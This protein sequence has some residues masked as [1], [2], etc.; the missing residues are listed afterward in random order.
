MS[1]QR[2]PRLTAGLAAVV[3]AAVGLTGLE[4]Q[5]RKP[6]Y[7]ASIAAAKARMRTG[8]GRNYPASWLYVRPDLPIK[9]VDIYRDWR[10]V[11]DPGGTQGWMQ[12][13]LLSD[14]R[15]AFVQNGVAP[16]RDSPSASARVVW[17]AAPGVVGRVSRCARGWCY[18]DVKGRGGFVEAASLWGV[19]PDEDL[20]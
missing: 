4:A 19:A 10:K 13:G 7:Y 6:P 14:T 20:D 18:I 9:V 11:E 3:I 2:V 1:S 8:P 17:R 15:T 12:V 5:T 16:L